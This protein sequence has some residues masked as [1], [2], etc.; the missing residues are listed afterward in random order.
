MWIFS[1]ISRNFFTRGYQSHETTTNDLSAKIFI[2]PVAKICILEVVIGLGLI[3]FFHTFLQWTLSFKSFG[4][5]SM[6]FQCILSNI[7]GIS[8]INC[9][10]YFH[11]IPQSTRFT[12]AVFSSF[13]FAKTCTGE[14]WFKFFTSAKK[15]THENFYL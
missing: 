14:N 8:S 9:T 11:D 13:L 12:P 1:R 4:V 7:N 10:H 3:L 2:Q 15:H 5:F 6:R